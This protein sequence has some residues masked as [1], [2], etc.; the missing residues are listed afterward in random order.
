MAGHHEA[1]MYRELK[2]SFPLR[3]LSGGAILGPLAV[4]AGL[5]GAIGNGTGILMAV[6]MVYGC[7]SCR[8]FINHLLIGP[9]KLGNWHARVWWTRDGCL[10]QFWVN[11]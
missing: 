8:F 9:F 7:N 1:S 6:M 10:R 4:D 3:L 2:L 5:S 11:P